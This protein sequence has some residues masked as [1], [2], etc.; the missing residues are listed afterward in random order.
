MTTITF[1]ERVI[2][3][4]KDGQVELSIPMD[5][6][7]LNAHYVIASMHLVKN[8][9]DNAISARYLE[10]DEDG[11]TI[12]EDEVK[13]LELVMWHIDELMEDVHVIYSAIHALKI[14]CEEGIDV[15]KKKLSK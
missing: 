5:T 6:T 1:T 13:E 11:L 3:I 10:I 9:Y 12:Y 8:L 14:V 2:T 15:L 4:Y 7:R